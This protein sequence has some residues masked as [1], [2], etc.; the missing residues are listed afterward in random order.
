MHK[1]ELVKTLEHIRAVN[2]AID[3][4][5]GHLDEPLTLETV[6]REASFS[7]YHFHRI[8]KA[9]VQENIHEYIR[10][11]RI[12]KSARLLTFHEDVPLSD[13]AYECG[14]QSL[15]TFSRAFKIIRGLPPSEYRSR[16]RFDRPR[17]VTL[18]EQRFRSE[19]SRMGG[20]D[21]GGIDRLIAYALEQL[22]FVEV[23][24]F[25]PEKVAY[26]RHRGL[27]QGLNRELSASFE[28]TYV[29][30]RRAGVRPVQGPAIGV[31]YDD[32]Y[33][34]PMDKSRYDACVP[35]AP[36]CPPVP[37]V[38]MQILPGGTYATLSISDT[39][40]MCALLGDLLFQVWLP[41]S[42]YRLDM[43]PLLEKYDKDPSYDPYQR[44]TLEI[45]IPL[46]PRPKA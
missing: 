28:R 34:T 40:Y 9:V 26:T 45:C 33:V 2:L 8:F 24:R 41:T 29:A 19:M 44:L 43:R 13:I 22:R 4:I 12:E 14:F 23:R 16:F 42:G 21:V 7:P 6:A 39:H 5:H 11:A 37:G 27:R 36:D 31:S 17:T 32:P 38:E 1:Y 3:Y 18:A 10:R 15:S 35:V 30:L 25:P 20:S 46:A